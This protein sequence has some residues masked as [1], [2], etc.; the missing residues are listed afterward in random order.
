MILLTLFNYFLT[1]NTVFAKNLF[2]RMNLRNIGG[3]ST[4]FIAL[5]ATSNKNSKGLNPK[6]QQLKSQNASHLTVV[7]VCR[8]SAVYPQLP[9]SPVPCAGSATVF[10]CFFF[11][12]SA[13]TTAPCALFLLYLLYTYLINI[14]FFICLVYLLFLDLIVGFSISPCS[15]FFSELFF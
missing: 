4:M 14:S 11:W 9:A 13:R 7:P 12:K 6:M 3:K 8:P 1:F 2:L 10:C 5:L 15:S